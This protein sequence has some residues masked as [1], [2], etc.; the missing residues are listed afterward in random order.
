MESGSR[1]S[2]LVR[3]RRRRR[4]IPGN[5]GARP[6]A[7]GA[8]RR[9]WAAAEAGRGSVELRAWPEAARGGRCGPWREGPSAPGRVCWE[10]MGQ[11]AL[12]GGEDWAG[13]ERQGRMEA[14]G[15]DG[16]LAGVASGLGQVRVGG[17]RRPARRRR[18]RAEAWTL[19]SR[20]APG[21]SGATRVGA[22]G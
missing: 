15:T 2:G 14:A 8:G 6:W 4:H 19:G 21:S 5:G 1:A 7:G 20:P 11:A 17:L 16:T 9:A 12:A 18:L 3:T 10:G 22:P 13:R